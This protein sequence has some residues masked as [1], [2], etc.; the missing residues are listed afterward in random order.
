MCFGALD[1]TGTEHRLPAAW[2][3]TIQVGYTVA[4]C[5]C[6]CSSIC[7]RHSHVKHNFAMHCESPG[8]KACHIQ[9]WGP[10]P[11]ACARAKVHDECP[12]VLYSP[13]LCT[14]EAI[15]D[16][17]VYTY[18]TVHIQ[19]DDQSYTMMGHKAEMPGQPLMSKHWMR[20][21]HPLF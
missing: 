7:S 10:V 2:L 9:F 18:R 4:Q 11:S 14:W 17:S 3:A 8:V 1:W 12:A 19:G 13:A 21:R 5:C 20:P 6:I 15:Q 16:C